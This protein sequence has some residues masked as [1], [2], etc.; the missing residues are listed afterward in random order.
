MLTNEYYLKNDYF[1]NP[2]KK[3]G[4]ITF[5]WLVMSCLYLSAFGQAKFGIGFTV[6]PTLCFTDLWPQLEGSQQ[7][8]PKF[9]DVF[10]YST[11]FNVEYQMENGFAIA[12]GFDLS[13]KR[14]GFMHEEDHGGEEIALWGHSEYHTVS[15][16]ITASFV[17]VS[18]SDPFFEIAPVVGVSFGADISS[19]R[20]LTRQDENFS[21]SYVFDHENYQ[22]NS[23]FAAASAGVVFKTVISQLGV[24]HWGAT[25]TTDLSVLP[26]FD[27]TVTVDGI[28]SDFSQQIRMNYFSLSMT[29]FFSTWEVFNGQLMKRNFY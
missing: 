22:K 6:E 29:Y 8:S 2:L 7:T 1:Q 19:Y 15:L 25:L 23:F 4:K 27:Y 10:N 11:S 28:P 18:G 3:A 5:L 26:S 14:F 13:R 17:L 16:P 24:M 21:Y 12:S 20:N 9:Q